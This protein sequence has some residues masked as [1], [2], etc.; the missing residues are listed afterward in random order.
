MWICL[1]VTKYVAIIDSDDKCS[2]DKLAAQAKYLDEHPDIDVVGC[3]IKFGKKT[4]HVS[5]PKSRQDWDN[6]YFQE[7]SNCQS[8]GIRRGRTCWKEA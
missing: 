8:Q 5:I 1:K 6:E 4:Q 7:E 3:K 2:P